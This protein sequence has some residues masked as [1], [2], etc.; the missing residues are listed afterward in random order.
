MEEET[1]TKQV[2]LREHILE[3][4]YDPEAFVDYLSSQRDNGSDISI[5]TLVDLQ[6]AVEQYVLISQPAKPEETLIVSAVVEPQQP[7]ESSQLPPVEHS[8][9]AVSSLSKTP[10]VEPPAKQ[11]GEA[12]SVPTDGGTVNEQRHQI[13]KMLLAQSEEEKAAMNVLSLW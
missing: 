8:V 2:Y 11:L 3:K 7:V 12:E 4:G 9:A 10:A 5:W 1:K 6:A 13:T